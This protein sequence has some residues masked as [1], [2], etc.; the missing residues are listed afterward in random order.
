MSASSPIEE[1]DFNVFLYLRTSTDEQDESPQ[2]QEKRARD[3]CLQRGWNVVGVY[4]DIVTGQAGIERRPQFLKMLE[5]VAQKRVRGF[6]GLTFN[7]FLR[8]TKVKVQMESELIAK[9]LFIWGI[10]DNKGMGHLP[11]GKPQRASDKAMLNFTV[12]VDQYYSDFISDK[13][14]DHHEHRVS[15]KLHHSGVPPFGY[16]VAKDVHQV[17]GRWYDGWVPDETKDGTAEGLTIADRARWIFQRFIE[18]ENLMDIAVEMSRLNVPTPRLVQ[19]NRLSQS[20]KA[21]RLEIQAKNRKA[22]HATRALPPSPVWDSSVLSDLIRSKAYLGM[23]AYT[24]DHTK[25]AGGK[26]QKTWHEG[27]QEPL[28]SEDTHA[29][30]V[31]IL[32]RKGQQVRGAPAPSNM[33]LLTG[34]L[35]CACGQAMTRASKGAGTNT[36]RYFCNL[37]KRSRGLACDMPAYN[38]N[39]VEPLALKLLLRGLRV[40]LTEISAASSLIAEATVNADHLASERQQLIK[41][42]ARVLENYEDGLYGDGPVSKAARDAKLSPILKRLEAVD[43]ELTPA[44]EPGADELADA[45]ANIESLWDEFPMHVKREIMMTYVP[46]GLNISRAGKLRAEVCGVLLEADVPKLESPQP[47]T[48]YGGRQKEEG[49]VVKNDQALNGFPTQVSGGNDRDGGIRTHDPHYPKV[50]R[51]QA[52]LRPEDEARIAQ[53]PKGAQARPPDAASPWPATAV[54]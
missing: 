23:I 52:A 46:G 39:H 6:V 15:L 42:R 47:G 35:H 16:R 34:M 54:G 7:R 36:Y 1:T 26:A 18:T 29:Q 51:Y 22:G 48:R 33:A 43:A 41:K 2:I 50:V 4:Y 38:S 30:I 17:A 45:L 20:E 25:T 10:D 12:T 27:R 44:E 13:I 49:Q 11:A 5:D 31:A 53:G 3:F 28:I 37:R 9:R 24:P 8:S 21:R 19:W 40:R 32:G 14:R